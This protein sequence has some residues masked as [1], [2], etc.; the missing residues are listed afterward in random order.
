[1]APIPSGQLLAQNSPRIMPIILIQRR[2]RAITRMRR[3]AERRRMLA[4]RRRQKLLRMKQLLHRRI[5]NHTSIREFKSLNDLRV[6]EMAQ[7]L[8]ATV[9][10]SLF[11]RTELE[12]VALKLY[13]SR[14]RK[15]SLKRKSSTRQI[16]SSFRGTKSPGTKEIPSSVGVCEAPEGRLA[17]LQASISFVERENTQFLC[18]AS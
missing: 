13:M 6:R 8:I 15:K 16:L 12:P 7:R 5:I 10:E 9:D 4:V 11:E 1:M 14:S 3:E 17:R 2:F 18:M